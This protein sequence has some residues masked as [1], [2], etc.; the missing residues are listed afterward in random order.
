[1]LTKSTAL[2]LGAGASVSF[3]FPTG[4]GLS[5]L[6]SGGLRPGNH[7][8]NVLQMY[9]KFTESQITSFR[10][11]FFFSGKNSVDAFLEHRTDLMTIGKAATAAILI[12][13]EYA[14][15]LFSYDPPNWL[16]HL[17][18][19]L[20]TSFDDFGSNELSIVTFNYD[21]TI[22]H[23]FFES[24]KNTYNKTDEECKVALD[25]LPIIH[26]H[27]RLG[28]LPWQDPKGRPYTIN[29]D[30]NS[31]RAATDGI[32]I[33]HEDIRD[34]RD[35]DFQQAKELMQKAVRILFLGF[36]YN[37]TNIERL[38]IA[39]LDAGKSFGMHMGLGNQD[40]AILGRLTN[41]RIRTYDG[42]CTHFIREFI[43]WT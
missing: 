33:I 2:V 3:G 21:R 43:P 7:A 12:G 18:N 32:K 19:N 35:G 17:Y 25:H 6:V 22:E 9:G 26:L 10:N 42:D 23:F 36:G 20:N 1:M 37:P 24:L 28:F 8:Y 11:A 13:Y 30:E 4:I 16:R 31:L 40:K 29:H 34:G 15:K 5:S 39:A 41:D 38:G 27:G 14:D